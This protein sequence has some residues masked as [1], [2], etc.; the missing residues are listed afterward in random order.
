M[1]PFENFTH[2]IH[3]QKH[4]LL[5]CVF[6][7]MPPYL[8]LNLVN[9]TL[10]HVR[11]YAIFGNR[12]YLVTAEAHCGWKSF[13][14]GNVSL[15]SKVIFQR[16]FLTLRAA[17]K[18]QM[19]MFWLVIHMSWHPPDGQIW[20]KLAGSITIPTDIIGRATELFLLPEV[21]R[22]LGTK[23]IMQKKRIN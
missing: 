3:L 13:L 15:R 11:M 20:P 7:Y 14:E 6:S 1:T 2:F 4:S 21:F 17:S 12:P 9:F 8:V 23:D 5:L 18:K 10:S 22:N 16:L 19:Q